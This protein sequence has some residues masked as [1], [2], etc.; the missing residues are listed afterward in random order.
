MTPDPEEMTLNSALSSRLLSPCFKNFFLNSKLILSHIFPVVRSFS[1]Q[2]SLQGLPGGIR[3]GFQ[4]AVCPPETDEK[5]G[6][7][8]S[9]ER[10]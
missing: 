9:Y 3:R 2:E 1:S 7:R 10:D 6:Y 4:G 8:E 5:K